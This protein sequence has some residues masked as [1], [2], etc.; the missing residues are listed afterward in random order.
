MSVYKPKNSPYFH[1][2]FVWQGRRFHGSTGCRNRRD[3]LIF[4]QRERLAAVHALG[5][6][7]PTPMVAGAN[8][9]PAGGDE[10]GPASP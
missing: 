6:L 5:L 10:E 2:D 4:E 3:A 1:F 9:Q 8:S 7:A